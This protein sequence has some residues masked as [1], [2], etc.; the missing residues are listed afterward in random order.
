MSLN[1]KELEYKNY[2]KCLLVDNGIINL[3][4]TIDVGPR[5]I[6][7]GFCHGENIFFNDV[8][9]LYKY[10]GKEI[11]NYFGENSVCYKYGGHKF[12]TI[13]EKMPYSF[14]PDND[15]VV[16]SVLPNGVSFSPPVQRCNN[17][18]LS[19][20]IMMNPNATD[21]MVIHSLENH[22]DEKQLLGLSGSTDMAPGGLLIVPQNATYD[23]KYLPNRSMAFWPFSKMND[24]RVFIGNRYITIYQDEKITDKY[25]I[26]TNNYSNWAAYLINGDVFM[27]HYVHNKKARYPD[28]NSSFEVLTDKN[29]LEIK[30]LSPLYEIEPGATVRHVENWSLSKYKTLPTFNNENEIQKLLESL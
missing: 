26:G 24:K 2:G 12:L 9:R 15:P 3:I 28:F 13:P 1:V 18:A 25:K 16:Y 4:V 7:F 27:K 29:M 22:S 10:G 14:Y 17:I 30:T 6:S 5:I 21:I 19:I 23:S 20:E 11:R 8:E